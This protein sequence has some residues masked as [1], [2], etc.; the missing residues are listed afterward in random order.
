MTRTGLWRE[1]LILFMQ[2]FCRNIISIRRTLL[3]CTETVILSKAIISST[4]IRI[5]SKY[6]LIIFNDTHNRKITFPYH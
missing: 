2:G 5:I 1:L 4:S 3:Q 6:C